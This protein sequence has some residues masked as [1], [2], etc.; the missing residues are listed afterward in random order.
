MWELFFLGTWRHFSPIKGVL[1]LGHGKRESGSCSVVSDSLWPLGLYT[2]WNSPGQTT[3]VGSLFLLQGI[4]PTQGSNPGLSH[5]RRI[6]YQLSHKGSPRMSSLSLLQW[7]FLTQELNQGLLHCRRILYQLSY[8]GNSGERWLDMKRPGSQA[9]QGKTL[10]D[11]WGRAALLQEAQGLVP[12]NRRRICA[13]WRPL[14]RVKQRREVSTQEA[15]LLAA[16]S[17][18]CPFRHLME[19]LRLCNSQLCRAESWERRTGS[20]GD[21]R[22]TEGRAG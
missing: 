4:F 7:I 20:R 6:L 19:N 13:P 1:G 3:R 18:L 5:C 2:P 11:Q 15:K 14:G 8:H 17:N 22:A 9:D 16:G 12:T 10:G 21:G